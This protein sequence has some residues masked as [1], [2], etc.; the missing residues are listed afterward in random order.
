MQSK[1]TLTDDDPISEVI[2]IH[3]KHRC[4]NDRYYERGTCGV[5]SKHL[6]SSKVNLDQVGADGLE[7]GP[8]S[9]K[10]E[11][12]E[13]DMPIMNGEFSDRSPVE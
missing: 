3:T 10:D 11:L 2:H 13:N 6:H 4:S 1:P 8:D 9:G 5:R 7:R 12:D